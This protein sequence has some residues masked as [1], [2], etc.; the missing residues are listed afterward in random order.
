MSTHGHIG[1]P[2]TICGFGAKD[3]A[4]FLRKLREGMNPH[5]GRFFI[6]DLKTGRKFLVEPIDNTPHRQ[7]WGDINP[8]TKELEGDY[9]N[10]YKGS[11]KEEDSLIT[12][13]NGFKMHIDF[14]G[15]PEE[16]IRQY[17][18]L[19]KKMKENENNT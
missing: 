7:I 18:E 4:E 6:T 14:Q 1:M 13:E 15:S 3:P 10:K 9:G 16:G 5:T 8:A 2:C 19:E 17:L 12:E 11:I